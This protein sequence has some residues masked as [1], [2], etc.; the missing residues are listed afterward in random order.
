MKLHYTKGY[1]YQT[2]R[3]YWFF[4]D[5]TDYLSSTWVAKV[6]DL[7]FITYN[8]TESVI[9]V[10]A[11]YAWDGP[12][13]PTKDDKTNMR[14]SF[15]HDVLYQMIRHYILRRSFRSIA[16]EQFNKTAKED[17]MPWWRRWYYSRALRK[18]AG[19]A[20]DPSNKKKVHVVGK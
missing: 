17:G 16:D 10:K 2:E 6:E 9:T 8:H 4:I 13:G 3:D 12:S 15:E 1:K 20:A 14:A 11:G 19:F 5:L 18:F 7:T